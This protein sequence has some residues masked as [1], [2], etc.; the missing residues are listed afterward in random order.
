MEQFFAG[1]LP[2]AQKKPDSHETRVFSRFLNTTVCIY[3]YEIG[4]WETSFQRNNFKLLN[5]RFKMIQGSF[6]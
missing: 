6:N 2:G 4:S 3:I 1:D 5:F